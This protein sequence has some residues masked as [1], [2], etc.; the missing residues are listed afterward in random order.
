MKLKELNPKCRFSNRVENYA[1]YR[2]NYPNEIIKFLNTTIGLTKGDIIA[3]IGSGTG[4]SSKLFLD[5]GNEVYGIEPNAEMRSAGEKSLINYTNFHSIDASSEDTKLESESVD[6]IT[7]GQAFHWFK[8]ESTKK[9]FLRILKS[10][11]FVVIFNNRRKIS[12]SRF[13][14]EYMEL[15]ENYSAKEFS[16]SFNTNLPNFFN[17]KTIYKEV[18]SNPQ[19]FNLERLKGDLVSYSYIPNEEEPIFNNMIS[20]FELLF[21]KYNNNG[22]L[23]FNYET[24]LYYCKMK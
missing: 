11:G 24:V 13:M 21:E 1:K 19:V 10:D 16:N 23:I 8:P 7:S 3:D 15:I 9:E 14:N 17:L 2:P 4:I 5:N 6:I 22:T 12:N 18:F 20:E